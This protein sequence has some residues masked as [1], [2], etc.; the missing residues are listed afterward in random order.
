M[1]FGPILLHQQGLGGVADAGALG[2]G[3]YHYGLR[4]G[5]ICALV[6]VDVAVAGT[7]LEYR[8]GGLLNRVVDEPRAAARDDEV[9]ITAQSEHL[10][11]HVVALLLDEADGVGGDAR[12]LK[13][14]AHYAHLGGVGLI[15]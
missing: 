10:V 6:D 1:R 15:G 7:C 13:R 8:H 3:V 14:V 11:D 2:L 12:A 5:V 4:H 9:D